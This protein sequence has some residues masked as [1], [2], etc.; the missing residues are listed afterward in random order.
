MNRLKNILIILLFSLALV[1]CGREATTKQQLD[2]LTSQNQSEEKYDKVISDSTNRLTSKIENL[3]VEYTVWG[4]ACPNWIRTEDNTS[5]NDT[6][7]NY[8]S[9][10]FYIEPADEFLELPIYFNPFE[11]RLKITGQFYERED[12]PQGTVEM[13][14][15]MPKAKVF[16][17]TKMDVMQNEQKKNGK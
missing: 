9:L 12:Y 15:P 8:L 1:S 4:C 5:L 6:T 10:H 2:N 13:E 14:E 7:E 3:E 17:Y 16:R 11:H